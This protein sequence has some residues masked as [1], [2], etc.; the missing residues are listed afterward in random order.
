MR[1]IHQEEKAGP[2]YHRES[3]YAGGS[4]ETHER[5]VV[6]GTLRHING[7]IV[8]AWTVTRR[9][10]FRAPRVHWVSVEPSALRKVGV[11][12]KERV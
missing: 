5:G 4:W 2:L 9:G 8:R 10:L 12:E 11:N 7:L 6:P 1:V 3:W